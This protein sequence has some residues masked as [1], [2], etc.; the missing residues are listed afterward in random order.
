[1][2]G[3][4]KTYAERQRRMRQRRKETGLVEVRERVPPDLAPELKRIAAEMRDPET[5][6]LYR[7]HLPISSQ[8]LSEEHD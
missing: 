4:D 7:Q 3:Y 5:A 8:R 6:N 2:G 1:M